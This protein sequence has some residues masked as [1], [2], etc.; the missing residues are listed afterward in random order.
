MKTIILVLL[1][2]N[3]LYADFT[4]EGNIVKD[5]TRKLAWQD[6][7]V[8]STM[9]WEDA[10]TQCEELTLDTYSDW[11]LPNINELLSIMS[12]NKEGSQ[13]ADAFENV[14]NSYYWSSTS[15]AGYQE[16]AWIIRTHTGHNAS[17][18]KTSL[19]YVKCVRTVE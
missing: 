7:N 18:N 1:S 17:N 9:V 4:K 19:Y 16:H 13:L 10:I 3:L 11:R 14:V 12:K 6:D 15:R 2:L 5:S 8:S